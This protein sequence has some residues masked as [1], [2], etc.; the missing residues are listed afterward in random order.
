METTHEPKHKSKLIVKIVAVVL[1]AVLLVPVKYRVTD[2]GSYG[3]KAVLY[4][5]HVYNA[6]ATLYPDDW[7]GT[8]VEI[9]PCFTFRI[10]AKA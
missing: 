4:N 3:Y 1:L 6:D 7:R 10:E 5:V 2:G 9:F 8:V